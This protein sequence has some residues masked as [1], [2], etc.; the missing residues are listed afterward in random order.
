MTGNVTKAMRRRSPTSPNV[1][2]YFAVFIHRNARGRW[3][4][5]RKC[6]INSY[7]GKKQIGGWPK[8][9]R[10]QFEQT[11]AEL[12]LLP[13]QYENSFA[14][15]KWVTEHKDSRYVPPSLLRAWGM[16]V[17]LPE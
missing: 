8:A 4:M 5:L 17:N 12:G 2:G 9:Q 15:R 3:A 13:E 1:L 10:T 7:W 14:L 6:A 11:V 16:L